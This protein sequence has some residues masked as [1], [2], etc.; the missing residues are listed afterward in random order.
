V[1]LTPRLLLG[2]FAD[3]PLQLLDPGVDEIDRVHVG[4]KGLLLRSELEA[5]LGKPPAPP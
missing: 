1:R 2:R 4:V 5:L 3:R